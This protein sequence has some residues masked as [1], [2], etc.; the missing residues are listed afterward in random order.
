MNSEQQNQTP[1]FTID[2]NAVDSMTIDNPED[3]NDNETKELLQPKNNFHLKKCSTMECILTPI[4]QI[5]INLEDT[6]LTSTPPSS[7]RIFD[8]KLFFII[9]FCAK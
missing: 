4:T 1:D 2:E 9:F 6:S 8:G 7:R 3:I 5:S